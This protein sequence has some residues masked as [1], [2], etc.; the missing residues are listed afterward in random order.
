MS[1]EF[2][3]TTDLYLALLRRAQEVEDPRLV[4]MILERLKPEPGHPAAADSGC[5]VIPFPI[6]HVQPASSDENA[7]FW[8]RMAPAQIGAILMVY[9]VLVIGHS[10][11]V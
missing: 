3:E 9:G 6:H 1:E 5:V 2:N 7:C 4:S 11:F 10:L 8:P